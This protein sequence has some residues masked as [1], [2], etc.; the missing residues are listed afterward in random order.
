MAHLKIIASIIIIC[1]IAI[2]LTH[3]E[4]EKH[5]YGYKVFGNMIYQDKAHEEKYKNICFLNNG[6]PGSLAEDSINENKHEAILRT[7]KLFDDCTN[8]TLEERVKTN[9]IILSDK[10]RKCIG[11]CLL[12]TSRCV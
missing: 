2:F 3:C 11:S 9:E 8:T 1:A 12:Y 6:Y 10:Q 5:G 7:K 4:K